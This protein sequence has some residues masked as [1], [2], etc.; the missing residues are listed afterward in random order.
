MKDKNFI[1]VLDYHIYKNSISEALE[2]IENYK[3]V[4]IIS[5]IQ[6]FCIVV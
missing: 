6:K 1:K 5:G 3:K 2:Y 4:H